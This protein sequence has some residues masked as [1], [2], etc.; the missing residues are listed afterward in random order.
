[1]TRREAKQ[2]RVIVLLWIAANAYFWFWWL[3]GGHVGWWPLFVVI[4][5]TTFYVSTVLCSAYL[6]FLGK[7]RQP[8]HI[9]ADEARRRGV[10]E[11]VAVIT[12]TVPGS[13]SIEIVERQ[14]RA[15]AAIDAPH[16]NWILVDKVHSPEIEQLAERLGIRYFSRHDVATWGEQRVAFWNQPS[17][18]FQRKTK[19]GNVNSWLDAYGDRY[20]H[21][22]QLD[23]DHVPEPRYLDRVLGYFVDPK[24]KWV[25]A[26]SVYGNHQAGWCARGSTE[27]EFGLQGPLQMGFFGFS[28]TPFISAAI[29]PTTWLQYARSTG[30]SRRGPRTTSTPS[31][32]RPGATRVSSCRR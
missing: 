4:S 12:L 13:E 8:V 28:R 16:D 18:P 11:R 32:S 10:V 17:A 19:A 22:T 26:P 15:M 30:F 3:R 23:I 2:H 24:V 31:A 6:F 21:F 27:Q 1:M 20:T 29:R 5:L 25:Q 14:L 9:D 7:M